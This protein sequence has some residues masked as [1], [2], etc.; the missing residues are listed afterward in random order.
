MDAWFAAS[1]VYFFVLVM[2]RMMKTGQSA[3]LPAVSPNRYCKHKPAALQEDERY[4]T[5]T[6]RFGIKCSEEKP[7][8]V[9]CYV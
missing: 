5:F 6:L 3:V 2:I 4:I 8:R 9:Y 1:G 7:K